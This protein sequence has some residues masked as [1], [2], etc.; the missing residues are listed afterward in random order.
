MKEKV[1]MDSKYIIYLFIIL[2]LGAIIFYYAYFWRTIDKINHIIQDS[3]EYLALS[4]NDTEILNNFSEI[5]DKLKN[6]ELI[7]NIWADF[8]KSLTTY[9]NFEGTQKLYSVNNASEYFS[10]SYFTKELNMPFWQSYGGIFTGLGILGTFGGLTLGLSGIDMSSSDIDVLKEGISGLLS[11]VQSAFI[12][13]LIGIFIGLIYG[14]FHNHSISNL[15]Q[16]IKSLCETIENLFPRKTTEQWLAEQYIETQDQNQT[17]KNLSEDVAR[18]L[19]NVLSEQI[20]G[21]ISELC[22]NLSEKMNP[23]FEK[24]YEAINEL[25]NSGTNTISQSISDKTGAQLDN[26]ATML[27]NLQNSLEKNIDSSQQI[28]N[29]INRKMLE[30]VNKVSTTLVQGADDV[31]NK[32]KESITEMQEQLAKITQFINQSS[33]DVLSKMSEMNEAN[34][35]KINESIDNV[36]NINHNI[37]KELEQFSNHNKDMLSTATQ[38]IEDN[39]NKTFSIFYNLLNQH[40][41]V[42]QETF[43]KT[44]KLSSDVK[45]LLEQVRET[46]KTLGN[47]GE[48]IKTATIN[49][50]EQLSLLRGET[51]RIHNS[52]NSQINNL[53][54]TNEQISNN[55]SNLISGMKENYGHIE[56][57]WLKYESNFNKVSGELEKATDIITDRLQK[58]NEMMNSG[59]KESLRMFDESVSNATGSLK[60]I[61]EELG[62]DIADFKKYRSR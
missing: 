40:K 47:V 33:S 20:D 1:L 28:T 12:T 55:V 32:Q 54:H 56:S 48:P 60:S 53:T 6:N 49:L 26:F 50:T 19:G 52:L 27:Q 24:L 2:S 59:M 9:T 3:K 39:L 21:G 18:E 8:S 7:G 57:A 15:R 31:A 34:Q 38:N 46:T 11:G 41:E 42:M 29:G 58:Y 36:Q 4:N 43:D 13:S 44:Q 17:L 14:F 51:S 62:D 5:D 25:T 22:N 30:T 61:A 23:V 16:N 10:F 35:L 45:V 37:M